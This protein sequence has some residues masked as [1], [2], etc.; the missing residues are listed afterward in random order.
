MTGA[1]GIIGLIGCFLLVARVPIEV[2]IYFGALVSAAVC[3]RLAWRADRN[4]RWK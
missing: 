3:L 4:A 1:L 2:V